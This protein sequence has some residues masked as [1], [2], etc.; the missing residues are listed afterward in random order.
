M[1]LQSLLARQIFC[2]AM[3][4][5]NISSE[6]NSGYDTPVPRARI[7]DETIST[8][9]SVKT[10]LEGITGKNNNP[11]KRCHAGSPSNR[12]PKVPYVDTRDQY[13]KDSRPIYLRLKTLYRKRLS[14]ASNIKTMEGKLAKNIFPA[15]I[16]FKIKCQWNKKIQS[17]RSIRKCKTDMTHALLD[18]LQKNYNTKAQIAKDMTDLERLLNPD[19]LQE[20]SE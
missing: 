12:D 3:L 13:P 2:D 15:S 8:L 11:W 20:I 6:P 1:P 10:R 18:D 16:D 7:P 9:N 4:H 19:Q 5:V 14:I 17:I